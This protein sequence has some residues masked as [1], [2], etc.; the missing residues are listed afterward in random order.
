MDNAGY[1]SLTRQ[2]GL[3]REMQSIANNIANIS[4]TG[5]RKEGVIFSEFVHAM[6]DGSASLSMAN[7]DVRAIN[8]IQGPLTQTGGQFDFAVEGD[9]FFMI[10]TPTGNQLTR[11]GAFTPNAAGELVTPDGFQLLDNGEAPVFIPPD[12]RS[13]SVAAD[14]TISADGR[15]L[16]QLGVFLPNDPTDLNHQEGTRFSVKNGVQP[17]EGPVIMQ[18]FLEGSNVNAVTEIARMI[19]VQHA[20][21]MGQQFLNKEDERIRGVLQTL[22]K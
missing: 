21:E 6:D 7:G 5:F 22:G 1:V 3:E 18:G 12:A 17:I 8:Q 15:P 2:S 11:A 20:Y 14:G 19:Q 9:G 4:T 13:V 16:A 10:A